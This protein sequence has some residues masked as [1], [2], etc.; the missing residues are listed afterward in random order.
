V[1]GLKILLLEAGEGIGREHLG[2]LV[3]VVARR[4]AAREDVEKLCWK[5]LNAGGVITATWLRT[6]SSSAGI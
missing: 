5:R 6:S 2:P 1:A 4:V 3:A